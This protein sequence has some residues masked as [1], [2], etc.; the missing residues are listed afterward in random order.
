MI[1]NPINWIGGALLVVLIAMF[2]VVAYF[3]PILLQIAQVLLLY[4][5]YKAVRSAPA[6][7][8]KTKRVERSGQ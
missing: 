4:L 5:I 8:S 2:E 1:G 7:E 3:A 6:A